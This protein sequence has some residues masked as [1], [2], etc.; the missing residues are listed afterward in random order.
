[1]KE[2]ERKGLKHWKLF[3]CLGIVAVIA[4]VNVLI[5][6]FAGWDKAAIPW[7]FISDQIL[8]MKWLSALLW[9]LIMMCVKFFVP[10]PI[11]PSPLGLHSPRPIRS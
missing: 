10:S 1:M 11:R 7:N 6:V 3:L 9:M 5:G 4:L 8:G 2:T